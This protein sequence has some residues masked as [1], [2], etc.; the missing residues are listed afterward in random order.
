MDESGATPLMLTT[1]RE[2]RSAAGSG[3]S[4]IHP[5]WELPQAIDQ[6]KSAMIDL[7][8]DELR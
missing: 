2:Q 4:L 6:S 3:A 1:D 7:L 8:E 5:E